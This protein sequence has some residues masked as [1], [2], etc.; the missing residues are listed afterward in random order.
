MHAR[1]V[2]AA[3][4]G[5]M[6]DTL[7]LVLGGVTVTLMLLTMTFAAAAFGDRFRYYSFASLAALIVFG[8]LT[9]VDAPGI[10]ANMPTPW[11]GLWQRINIGVFLLWI[12]V[13]A[14][15]LLRDK[16]AYHRPHTAI[17]L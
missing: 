9:F 4:G 14:T 5:T 13:L 7:H 17:R 15:V 11:L 2:L 3:G 6:S 1:E 10:A 8:V 12:V 16:I